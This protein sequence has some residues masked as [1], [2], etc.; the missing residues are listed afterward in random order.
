ML[1]T[2]DVRSDADTYFVASLDSPK[3]A[4]L[5]TDPR[6]AL[7]FQSK[8]QFA[9]HTGTGPVVRDRKLI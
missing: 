4:A 2:K 5:K 3:V 7:T 6:V 1:M 8:S 9:S